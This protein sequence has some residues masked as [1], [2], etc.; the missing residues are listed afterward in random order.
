[1]LLWPFTDVRF[2]PPVDLFYG[3]HWS[4]GLTSKR[5]LW[6]IL[7][8]GLFG[9]LIAALTHSIIRRRDTST[10]AEQGRR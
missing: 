8:E 1:M 4:D 9:L 10:G 7:T 2:R 3:L 5:H 6:T